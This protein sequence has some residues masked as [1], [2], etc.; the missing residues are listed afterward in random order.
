[1]KY[2][3]L[4]ITLFAVAVAMQ[5]KAE[6][7]LLSLNA[8][9]LRELELDSIPPWPAELVLSGTNKHWQKILHQGEFVVAVYEAEAAVIDVSYPFPY[10]EYVL[11]LEG[12]VT[13]TSTAGDKQTYRL[14]DSFVV[15][16]GWAGTWAMPFTYRERIVVETAAWI[17]SE[18]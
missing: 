15:A 11:V 18:E 4:A 5:A 12:E 16:K 2:L 3:G 7:V 8:D 6:P 10:D 14:E 17:A 13:L 1:M 9:Q